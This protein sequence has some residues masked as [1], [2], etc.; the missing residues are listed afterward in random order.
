[1]AYELVEVCVYRVP[2]NPRL[3]CV[4]EIENKSNMGVLPL[5]LKFRGSKRRK[6]ARI[7]VEKIQEGIYSIPP[8]LVL[9]APPMSKPEKPQEP[10]MRNP[11]RKA[12]YAD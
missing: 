12:R 10:L 5:P 1:M 6:G 7:W 8:E 2:P 11:K 4:V 9:P 3:V